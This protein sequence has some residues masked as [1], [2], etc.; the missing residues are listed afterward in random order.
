MNKKNVFLLFTVIISIVLF[1]AC[2]KDEV[3]EMVSNKGE[4]VFSLNLLKSSSDLPELK[5]SNTKESAVAIAITIK[6]S[7]GITVMEK[8]EV[9]LLKIGEDFITK[10]VV[11]PAGNYQLTEF[12]VFDVNR[13]VIYAAPIEGTAYAHIVSNPLPIN[14]DVLN[15]KIVKLVPEV[16]STSG[17]ISIEDI[18]YAAF[19]LNIVEVFGTLINVQKYNQTIKNYEFTSAEILI[20]GDG[21]TIYSGT[22]P[23]HTDS[24]IIKDGY[25]NYEVTITKLGYPPIDTLFTNLELKAY[26][27]KPLSFLL[28]SDVITDIDGN[29]Y[30]VVQ[31]GDQV[32]MAENL[33][34]TKYNNGTVIPLITDN[35]LWENATSGAYC[36]YNNDDAAYKDYEAL[37]NWHT[38]ETDKLC[39]TGWHVPTNSDWGILSRYLGGKAIAGGKLKETGTSH[40]LAPNK[41]ATNETGFTALPGGHRS[42]NGSFYN[43]GIQG[44]WWSSSE[45]GETS[46]ITRSVIYKR[47]GFSWCYFNKKL[48]LSVR[49]IRNE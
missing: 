27:Q 26:N 8:E 28:K 36:Y 38:V 20:K 35:T 23:A 3:T 13:K 39:P 41:G 6:N 19:D 34:T 17:L 37:Y 31:I 12:L 43:V 16:I 42:S 14:F 33:K 48:G 11:L 2:N 24:I 10:S 29:I 25:N 7:L 32:W 40:W 44:M 30:K 46:A 45:K 15:D 9:K 47:P 22:I 49:C 1:N 5:S 4:L 18:G 21:T